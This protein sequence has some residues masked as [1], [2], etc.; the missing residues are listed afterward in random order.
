MSIDACVLGVLAVAFFLLFRLLLFHVYI[1]YK[2]LTTYQYI[3]KTRSQN[4]VSPGQTKEQILLKK[5]RLDVSGEE[6]DAVDDS[7][8][9]VNLNDS[10]IAE[11]CKENTSDRPTPLKIDSPEA[12]KD[13]NRTSSIGDGKSKSK[14]YAVDE[15]TD[16]KQKQT[17]KDTSVDLVHKRLEAQKPNAGQALREDEG[18]FVLSKPAKPM[19]AHELA[20][21]LDTLKPKLQ[22]PVSPLAPEEKEPGE[23]T[24]RQ[25]EEG[26]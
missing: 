8:A 10:L 4:K 16:L 21:E 24:L 25:R 23:W 11:G 6:R 7:R 3:L 12:A 17:E 9:A 20:S 22:L 15:P 18:S 13:L 19:A 5:V 1:R 26:R 14:K 2:G